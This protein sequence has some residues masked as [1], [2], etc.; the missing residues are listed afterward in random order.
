MKT[1][2]PASSRATL[3]LALLVAAVTLL[4]SAP[5]AFSD[6]AISVTDFTLTA[7]STDA[8]VSVDASSSTSLSYSNASE[9]VKMTIGHFARGMIANPE[10]VPHC[11]QALFLADNCPADTRIGSSV[12][13]IDLTPNLGVIQTF[14]GRIYNQE[15]LGPEAGRLG[16]IVDTTPDKTFL[17]APFYVRTNGDFGLDGVLD[18]LPRTASVANIQIKRLAFTLFGVVNGRKFTRTPTACNLHT[19]TGEA[20]GYDDPTA[21]SG[22]A[23]SYTPT[24]CGALPFKPTFAM[25]LASKGT[26]A[27]NKHPSLRVTVT[28]Q[29]GEAG[30]LGNSV[31]LPEILTVNTAAFQTLCTEAQL[32]SDSCPPGSKVGGSHATSPFLATPLAGPVWL[33]QKAGSVLPTLVADLRGRVPIKVNIEN[34]VIGGKQLKATVAN[35]PDLPIGSFSLGLDGGR[36]GVLLNKSNLCFEG[37][38][39]SRFRT[40]DA[41]V[42]FSGH[43]GANLS[44]RPSIAVEGCEPALSA[45]LSAAEGSRLR[46]RLSV[47][48]HPDAGKIEQAELVLSRGL[49]LVRGKI[50]QGAAGQASS[51][52]ER[53]SFEV[54]SRRRLVLTDLPRGGAASLEVRLDHGAIRLSHKLRKA[55]RKGRK[56]TLRLKLISTDTAGERFVSR[57]SV[58]VRVR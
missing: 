32:A 20:F 6:P 9:D 2:R 11:P 15:L 34:S 52:L 16:I 41:A 10:A 8:G 7:A 24:N 53:S 36:N 46:L 39:S 48:R 42:T 18:D 35:V 3:A 28:Q 56:K 58:R 4:A 49:R 40:L 38:S 51:I 30:V 47:E 21:V 33:V 50:G 31:T 23:S 19:S 13:D 5:P 57:A 14:T 25:S 22:P 43:S 1:P 55:L 29:P 26:T 44:S 27:F 37:D 45:S 17:T 54:R 12:A